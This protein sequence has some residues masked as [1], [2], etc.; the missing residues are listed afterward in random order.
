MDGEAQFKVSLEDN[1]SPGAKRAQNSIRNAR[2]ALAGYQAQLAQAS[3]AMGDSAGFAK[4]SRLFDESTKR[5][6][7]GFSPRA[8]TAP[9]LP[10]VAPPIA[11]LA[12]AAGE[13]S[14]GM[15]EL[16]AA[17]GVYGEVAGAAYGAASKLAGAFVEL[18]ESALKLGFQV[19]ETNARLGAMFEALGAA[20]GAGKK[21]LA[22]LDDVAKQLPQS[23]DQLGD[24]TRKIEKMG[25][26]DLSQI[27]SELVATASAH[28][29]LGEAGGDAYDKLQSKIHRYAQEHPGKG[30]KLE[31][32]AL[33]A[34]DPA[35]EKATA[36]RMGMSV[37]Q[38]AKKL[39]AG[40]VDAQ[41]FSSALSDVMRSKGKGPLDVAMNSL[42]ALSLK[43]AEALGHLFD[44]INTKP[45]TDAIKSVISLGDLG[46]PTGQN[47]KSGVTIGMNGLIRAVGAGINEVEVLFLTIELDVLLAANALKP[48][49][50]AF[51]DIGDGAKAALAPIE[52]LFG[53]IHSTGI[54]DKLI[55]P[56]AQGVLA[57]RSKAMGKV[58]KLS[59][60]DPGSGM[61]YAIHDMLEVA[62]AQSVA[63]APKRQAAAVRGPLG[64]IMNAPSSGAANDVKQWIAPRQ[65]PNEAALGGAAAV[66]TKNTTNHTTH[67]IGSIVVNVTAPD[68]VTDAQGI[69]TTAL[70]T[71]LERYQVAAGR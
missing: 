38:L 42:G 6:E 28:A 60:L 63:E 4:Y 67:T 56:D 8:R 58:L 65:V 12:P 41:A 27:R 25:V 50:R 34:I 14:G 54:V 43:A 32:R 19:T 51:H 55:P 15:L 68:G 37:E 23:R 16:N 46:E 61:V 64:E 9:A 20:P 35:I 39:K 24:W 44:E 36:D 21:T 71:A 57:D 62:G 2:V 26:T 11:K 33:K 18:A 40:T 30:L 49:V 17:L 5:I 48:I 31:S 66:T 29:L 1:V 7:S 45:I 59:M 13:A 10:D 47:L 22:L 53:L 69:S 70:A 52:S 3:A